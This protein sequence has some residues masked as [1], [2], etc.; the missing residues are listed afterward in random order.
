MPKNTV[1]VL[2]LSLGA[3]GASYI[4]LVLA[5]IF[6]ASWQTEL[7]RTAGEAEARIAVLETEYYDAIGQLSSLDLGSTGLASPLHVRYV[8]KDGYPAVTRVDR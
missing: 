4:V 5:A 6:F 2:S 3:T 8:A 1:A 7:S